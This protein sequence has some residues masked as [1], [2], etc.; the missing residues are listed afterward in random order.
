MQSAVNSS[1]SSPRK[2]LTLPFAM[3]FMMIGAIFSTNI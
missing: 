3:V 2:G 1:L